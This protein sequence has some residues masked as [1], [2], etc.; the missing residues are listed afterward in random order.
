MVKRYD[1]LH[2]VL[3]RMNVATARKHKLSERLLNGDAVNDA[4]QLLISRT[5]FEEVTM[6]LQD[7]MMTL[8]GVRCAFDRVIGEYPSMKDRLKPNANI[9]NN[10]DLESGI[11]K[12]IMG[13]RLTL[14]EREQCS[15]FKAT[16]W[17]SSAEPAKK[18]IFLTPAFK[19][20]K[21]SQSQ[22]YTPV[23]WVP[24]TSNEC[25]RFFSQAKL[26]YTDL[27]KSM[28]A[29]TLQVLMFL[30]Y[31]RDAWNINSIKMIRANMGSNSRK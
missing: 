25:E 1:E 10:A 21:T 20:R 6:A 28:D 15:I 23:D 14:E 3:A 29:D 8:A 4:R 19:K 30:S 12:I 22:S 16:E 31:N 5:H 24:P 27:R 17:R 26:V 9:V 11:V 2:D 13:G 7:S 18:V